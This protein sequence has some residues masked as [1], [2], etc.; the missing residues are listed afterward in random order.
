MIG[1]EAIQ[2]EYESADGQ[3]LEAGRLTHRDHSSVAYT[4][5]GHWGIRAG[6]PVGSTPT[7]LLVFQPLGT[8]GFRLTVE[9]PI[10]QQ[11]GHKLAT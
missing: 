9:H 7:G 8:D 10:S 2:L 4:T 1:H 3:W 5:A 11:V 6:P